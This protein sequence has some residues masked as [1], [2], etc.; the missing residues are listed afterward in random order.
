M[1]KEEVFPVIPRYEQ[2]KPLFNLYAQVNEDFENADAA[3]LRQQ[4]LYNYL[5]SFPRIP[6]VLV[7]GEA[8]GW[9]GCRFS[10]VPF[11]SEAQ[12]ASS[13]L[14]FSGVRTSLFAEPLREISASCF[15]KE[16]QKFHPNFLAWNCMPFHPHQPD[17]PISNRSL[18]L[19]EMRVYQPILVHLIRLLEPECILAVGQKAALSLGDLSIPHIP[20]RHPAHGGYR[21]FRQEIHAA[22]S[23]FRNYELG[24]NLQ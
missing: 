12:L 22:L 18:S 13:I 8:P 10:G 7:I 16:L 24:K 19:Q 2:G 11:T 5:S 6:T 20:I 1:L 15:W 23:Q 3:Q 9:R 4:N 17:Q 21:Q 14:P